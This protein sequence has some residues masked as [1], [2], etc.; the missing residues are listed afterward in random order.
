MLDLRKLILFLSGLGS[1]IMVGVGLSQLP[2]QSQQIVS[3]TT[4]AQAVSAANNQSVINSRGFLI[5][6]IGSGGFVSIISLYIYLFSDV[7]R[8]EDTAA[9]VKPTS[10]PRVINVA[11]VAVAPLVA[12][13]VSKSILKI[14]RAPAVPAAPRAPVPFSP[15]STVVPVYG[16][17]Y[18]NKAEIYRKSMAQRY[19][20]L[21]PTV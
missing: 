17:V 9:E 10:T 20:H 1:L 16:T 2:S 15:R 5:A 4:Q 12:A 8:R 19:P 14:T 6:M 13:P 7:C 3:D 21:Q 11:P 18:G